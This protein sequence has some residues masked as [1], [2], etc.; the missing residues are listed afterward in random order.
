[1][2]DRSSRDSSPDTN[3]G[4]DTENIDSG[5]FTG[6]WVFEAQTHYDPSDSREL[7]TAVISA[8]AEAESASLTEIESPPL[9]E[10]IDIIDIEN[11]LFGRGAVSRGDT[12]STVEFEYRGHKVSIESDGWIFVC[13]RVDT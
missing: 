3:E 8:I 4:S 5:P 2:P 11:A 7:T 9:H 6:D 13:R 12:E 1:M 10:V